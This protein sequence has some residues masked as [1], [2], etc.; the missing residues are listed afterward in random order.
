MISKRKKKPVVV[1]YGVHI[2]LFN[3]NHLLKLANTLFDAE[4]PL[5]VFGEHYAYLDRYVNQTFSIHSPAYI[6]NE[7]HWKP[8]LHS[9]LRFKG[10]SLEKSD[11]KDDYV[12]LCIIMSKLTEELNEVCKTE[13]G[14]VVAR[15][16]A[17]KYN[18][19][20]EYVHECFAI[21][22][23][24]L[25]SGKEEFIKDEVDELYGFPKDITETTAIFLSLGRRDVKLEYKHKTLS[26]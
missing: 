9:Y 22:N 16:F 21:L 7:S 20:I 13:G 23:P 1:L 19:P 18:Y 2:G 6:P 25:Q 4:I 17:D 10:P 26:L 5:I 8:T 11:E 3:E 12:L 15:R 24:F 14:N